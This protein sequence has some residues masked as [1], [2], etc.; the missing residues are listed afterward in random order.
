MARLPRLGAHDDADPHVFI[1]GAG[2]SVAACPHGDR[3]GRRLPL[4]PNLVEVVGL[5]DLL[6]HAQIDG[7]AQDFEGVYDTLT[8]SPEHREVVAEL[9]RRVREYFAAL[10]LPEHPTAYDY[11]LASLRP[12]DLVA[13]FNWDPL[14]AQAYRRNLGIRRLPDLAFL[15]GNVAVG[16]CPDDRRSGWI[17]DT[18]E[19]CGKPFRPAPLLYP[20]RDKDYAKDPFIANE[21]RNLERHVER[22]YF[23]SVFGYS[24]PT[25]DAAAREA[26]MR[27]WQLNGARELAEVEIIDVKNE[28]ELH[29]NWEA[30]ITREHYL[31]GDDLLRTYACWHPR[32]SC[33]ALGAATLMNQPFKDDWIPA[34]ETLVELHAWIEP[35]LTEEE[36]LHGTG[37]TFSG[38]PCRDYREAP[39]D[40]R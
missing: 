37:K 19:T 12:K 34:F 8:R 23:L 3:N 40:P 11:L 26:M 7:P 9:E 24:A 32:R 21:W 35:L 16:Y 14:L 39:R 22:A 5:G 18:C 20:V 36:E 29:R 38:R 1:L 17:D 33:D 2:A 31:I 28:D 4:M 27:V 25:T 30:F 6:A 15:H 10:R 13:T